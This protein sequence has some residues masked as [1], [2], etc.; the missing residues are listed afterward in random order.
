MRGEVTGGNH[1][2]RNVE[3]AQSSSSDLDLLYHLHLQP[4]IEDLQSQI[5]GFSRSILKIPGF[6]G[7]GGLTCVLHQG[8]FRGQ[9]CSISCDRSPLKLLLWCSES[10]SNS[11]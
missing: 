5:A 11:I 9:V 4:R 2:L 6:A 1:G 8:L 10:D 3:Q 7:Q